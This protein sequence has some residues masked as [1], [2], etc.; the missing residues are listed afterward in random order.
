MNEE[1]R[2]PTDENCSIILA[3]SDEEEE[4]MAF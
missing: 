3:E 2:S 1:D 4:K